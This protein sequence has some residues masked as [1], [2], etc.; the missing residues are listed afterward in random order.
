MFHQACDHPALVCISNVNEAP[1]D[2][3]MKTWDE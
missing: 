1:D 3:S 2:V